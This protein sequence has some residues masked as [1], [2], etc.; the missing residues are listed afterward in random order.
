[1]QREMMPIM[2]VAPL[3]SPMFQKIEIQVSTKDPEEG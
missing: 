1:M 2:T 3:I